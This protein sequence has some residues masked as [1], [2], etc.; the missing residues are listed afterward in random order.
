MKCSR[1]GAM[2]VK[3][4][5]CFVIGSSCLSP[6]YSMA[7]D[8]DGCS[9][10]LDSLRRRA[11]DASSVASDTADKSKRF[12]D[13]E[14]ELRNCRQFPQVYDLLRDGCSFKRNEYESAKSNYQSQISS[15]KSSL[16]D[17]DSK[18]RDASGSCGYEL[19]RVNGPA[20]TIPE[21]VQN[22]ESCAI[23]LRYKSRLPIATLV[24]GCAKTTPIDQCRKCLG[25]QQ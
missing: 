24:D 11:S 9:S 18:V 25:V 13:A 19:T 23:W 20:P 8:W 16:D 22:K 6:T 5:M 7:Q 1:L 2:V 17:V 4:A 12:K 3:M 21:G 15:L 10:D 14:S